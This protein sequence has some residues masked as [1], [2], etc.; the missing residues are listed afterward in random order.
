MPDGA[1]RRALTPDE[2]VV[3]IWDEQDERIYQSHDRINLPKYTAPGFFNRFAIW[4]RSN[5]SP[6]RSSAPGTIGST[7][8]LI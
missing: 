7:P 1:V 8:R 3:Q 2:L 5:C 6:F 4:I